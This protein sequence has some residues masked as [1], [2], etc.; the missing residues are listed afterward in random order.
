MR[1]V[2]LLALAALALLEQLPAT[3]S[4]HM[5]TTTTCPLYVQSR[6]TSTLT[7]PIKEVVKRETKHKGDGS[8]TGSGDGAGATV[9][10]KDKGGSGGDGSGGDVAGVGTPT[11]ATRAP[12]GS[13]T[14]PTPTTR[15][16]SS[17]TPTPTT[18]TPATTPSA[19]A[20]S[21]AGGAG[22][23]T[24]VT[25]APAGAATRHLQSVNAGV[26]TNIADTV[27]SLVP[28][29]T[30]TPGTAT[31]TATG[32]PGTP[33]ATTAANSNV[34][35]PSA[36]ASH[37]NSTAGSNSTSLTSA[38]TFTC[39]ATFYSQWTTLGITCGAKSIDV[40]AAVAASS[41]VIYSGATGTITGSTCVSICSFPACTNG[42]W[43]YGGSNG[44]AS[45]VYAA[46]GLDA[47]MPAAM[48][49]RLLERAAS[50]A[51]FLANTTMNATQQCAFASESSF[52]SCA[53]SAL[54]VNGTTD[55]E[56][57]Q[58]RA[59]DE[60][61]G[62][63]TKDDTTLAGQ[64]LGP[65]SSS[66]AGVTVVISSIAAVASSVVSGASAA[67]ASVAAAGANVAVVTVEICQFGVFINQL[68]L[69][70]KSAALALFG[71]QM[72][73]SAF[74]FLP[75]GK[76]DNATANATTTAK[77]RGRRL[78]DDVT[79][80][81]SGIAKYARTLG[82]K[83]DMLFLVTLAGV[84]VLM[85]GVL[86]IFG[87]AYVAS[88]LFMSRED[89][90]TKFFD[91]MI[92]LELL[93]VILSQ[94]TIGVTGTYQIYHSV[95]L[96][97]PTDPKCILAGLSLL[98]IAVGIIVYGYI[99]VKKHE[100]ELKDVG[101]V[102]HLKKA[103]NM[104]YG[105]LYEE[106]KYKNRFF[107][108]PKMMLAL[109]TGCAT[110]YVGT[111]ATYQVSV[112]L[113]CHVLFFFYLEFKSPHHS[114]FVQTTTSFVT[115]MKIAVL[116]LTFFLINAAA[117][118][119]FPSELQNGISLAIVGLNLFVLFLLMVRSLYTFWQKYQL[120]RDAKYDEQDEQTAQ[121]YFKD[122]TPAQKSERV[123]GTQGHTQ[124][125]AA[126]AHKQV[127]PHEQFDYQYE[128]PPQQQYGH[129]TQQR[130]PY[131]N[132]Q[133]EYTID[134]GGEIRLRSGTHMQEAEQRGY[135]VRVYDENRRTAANH[136]IADERAGYGQ[137]RN[138]VVE[139]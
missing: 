27:A 101:T 116:V 121:D 21:S 52:A 3:H 90:M 106:Y 36:S 138:D 41:C 83:E 110:G 87:V 66:I 60:A 16:P 73:P 42:A 8:G 13:T 114:R 120:Q 38:D 122:D 53:C 115:I 131:V 61:N 74:T 88:G 54:L 129:P 104:R 58:E 75:F 29:P 97:N 111:E 80:P 81:D 11:P 84:I 130:S 113:G 9:G 4:A 26:T 70:G 79:Q 125:P 91:K 62:V 135:E 20:G 67:G 50:S 51:L 46:F 132:T 44:L 47:F 6:V 43:V 45:P 7:N 92:G 68:D 25:P 103:V 86:A 23:G 133:N 57:K 123:P 40:E 112:I 72:A 95:E 76:L 99:V 22:A 24:G 118:D 124:A 14:T 55:E 28:T 98:F 30:P 94:Y 1:S 19:N 109:V 102:G 139:L 10:D 33:L 15:A 31:G 35:A 82:I 63:I 119:G 5:A 37:S 71:K 136:Y 93:V 77:T 65:T 64:V 17:T 85:A 49:A 89:F 107:F 108:A 34:T 78:A 117:A 48:K 137:R 59:K 39:D 134:D 100:E 69:Q 32:T 127:P 56:K 105:P 128:Q 18:R 96:D 126:A 2:A 12:S